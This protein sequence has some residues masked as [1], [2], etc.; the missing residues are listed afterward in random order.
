MDSLANESP[1]LQL[2]G[3]TK[4]YGRPEARILVLEDVSFALAEGEFVALLGQSGSGKSTLLRIVM[5][6][7]S[8]DSGQV[9]YRG[10]PMQGINPHAAIIFQTFALYPWLTALEN[11]DLAL[12]PKGLSAEERLAQAEA[13]LDKVGL[14]GFEDAYPRE[15]SGGMRQ[16][17]GFARALAVQPELLLM[18]EPFTALDVLSA[19]NLR[20]ELL[21]LW[22]GRR[23]PIRAIL[24]VTHNIE[25]AVLLADRAIVLSRNPGRVIGDFHIALPYPR[26][27]KSPEFNAVVDRIYRLITR[28][29]AP[30]IVP[31]AELARPLPHASIDTIAGLTEEVAQHDN[32]EDLFQ[33][34][35]DLLL[36]VDELLPVT[37]AAEMLDLGVVEQGDFILEPLGREFAE[38]DVLRRK[39][40]LR[41]KVLEVPLV[42][43]IVFTLRSAEDETM[44]EEFFLN[45][46]RK[47][48]SEEEA[49]DQL[50]TA[51]DWGRY[52]ELFAYDHDSREL[53]LED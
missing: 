53:Y 18:D 38:A 17:V 25:E 8:P 2:A 49:R 33:L 35:S 11:V 34:A 10:Q 27:R 47:G 20:G 43:R 15:L 24:M 1:L 31:E 41:P 16:R 3:I 32:R 23:L 7:T 36:E 37:A 22:Q 29:V 28:V 14:D 6:L 39:E 42:R 46:L 26:S 5:G 50:E 9:L 4:Y 51:I 21:E 12:R 48:F 13:A 30:P 52:T 44:P 45:I 40:L 19:E